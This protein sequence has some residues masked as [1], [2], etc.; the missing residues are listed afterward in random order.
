MRRRRGSGSGAQRLLEQQMF[1]AAHIAVRF[2][3][4]D[5]RLVLGE[6]HRGELLQR[7]RRL[8]LGEAHRGELTDRYSLLC[9]A[10]SGDARLS[11]IFKLLDDLND[12]IHCIPRLLDR[13]CR[14][15][16]R[17]MRD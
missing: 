4:R 9:G 10:K 7:D 15:L 5:H 13:I 14:L 16:L 2:L 11:V 6:A 17:P 1:R 8:V 12:I 3:Q